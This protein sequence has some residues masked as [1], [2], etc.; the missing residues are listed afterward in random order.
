MGNNKE[1]TITITQFAVILLGSM[2]GIGILVLPNDVVKAAK[3][4]GWMACIIGMVYPL[5]IITMAIY[6]CKKFPKDNILTLSKKCFGKILGGILNFIFIMYFLFLSTEVAAGTC[7]VLLI[8]M[9]NF[10]NRK[11]IIAIILLL[12]VFISYKGI[13][14]LGR[15]GEI[16]FC[17][18]FPILF[19]LIAAL[20]QGSF[21]NIMPVFGSGIINI[22]KASKETAFAYSGIE[23][24][25]LIYPFLQDNKDIKKYSIGAVVFTSII[26]FWIT[27]VTIFYL[28]I[29]TIPKF[30]WSVVTL[31]ESV[32]IPVI[33]SFRYI[34][35]MLW[36]LIMFRTISN[37]YYAV[38]YGLSQFTKHI[39]R[40]QFAILMYPIAFYLSMKYGNP[41]VRRSFL[42]KTVPLY[43]LFNLVY[44]SAVALL[45]FIKKG[46]K[47]EKK[48]TH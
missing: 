35:M 36:N 26:Y 16:I 22:I 7:N 14:T 43:V 31:S 5:Y 48:V 1:N 32:I 20:K 44:V 9:V 10:L 11:K 21:L 45:L 40:K 19:I 47:H 23:I 4:D 12:P 33:N 39:S 15:V 17:I 2:I 42:S 27:F 34:F 38:V 37:D 28:G 8:Y 25:F 3:Q 46:D 6:M 29:E 30:L 18:T 13:N 41:T 24:I